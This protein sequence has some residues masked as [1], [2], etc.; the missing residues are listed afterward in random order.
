M[1][2]LSATSTIV[3]TPTLKLFDLAGVT[4]GHEVTRKDRH[5]SSG[6]VVLDHLLGGG[7]VPGRITE[8]V[9]RGHGW[10]NIAAAFVASVTRR[11]EAAAWIDPSNAFGPASMAMAGIDLERVLWVAADD[12]SISTTLQY[13]FTSSP[14]ARGRWTAYQAA[15]LVLNT[16]GFSLVVVDV[17]GRNYPLAQ[18]AALRLAHQ[19]ERSGTAVIVAIP[20]RT[21]GTFA[22]LYL[23][24]ACI[25]TFFAGSADDGPVTFEGFALEVMVIRN[26]LGPSGQRAVIEACATMPASAG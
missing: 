24:V 2:T 3:L 21:G 10:M 23:A 22:A 4:R 15:E 18:S 7:L 9:A 12:V 6:V 26:K 19:A 20:Q 17:S 11:G 13:E 14:P 16:G 8:I 5:L 25:D 1:T